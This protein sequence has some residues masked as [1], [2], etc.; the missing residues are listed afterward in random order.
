MTQLD[1]TQ[2][3]IASFEDG[4]SMTDHPL[5][6]GQRPVHTDTGKFA[7]GQEIESLQVLAKNSSDELVPAD[8]SASDGTEKPVAI[9]M[10]SVDTTDGETAEAPVYWSGCFN[11]DR[12]AWHSSWDTEEKKM[13]AFGDP[14][15][16]N[17][18]LK[19]MR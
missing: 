1:T 14:S 18:A 17:I 7:A 6:T 15:T 11:P 12:L 10:V 16:S 5:F 3:G 8:N 4:D 19:K 2:V 13:G 9:A